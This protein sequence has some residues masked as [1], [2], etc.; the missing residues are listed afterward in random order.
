MLQANRKGRTGTVVRM[1]ESQQMPGVA[2][3]ARIAL[4]VQAVFNVLGIGLLVFDV[5]DRLDHNQTVHPAAWFFLP[6]NVLM[7]I[8][9]WVSAIKFGT[10]PPWLRAVVTTVEI[11][12][13]I[14]GLVN[15][16]LGAPAGGFGVA[17]AVAV[18]A[19]L[20]HRSTSDWLDA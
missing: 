13:L 6:L 16:F 20:F 17:F 3:A 2:K 18:L 7:G 12:V 19:L 4:Y 9:L 11:A 10:R 8:G 1:L 14:N 5:A 15:V